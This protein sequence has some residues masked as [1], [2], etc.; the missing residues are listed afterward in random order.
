MFLPSWQAITDVYNDL[1][2][3]HADVF[4]RCY[5]FVLHSSLP[6]SEQQEVFHP[7]PPGD[8]VIFSWG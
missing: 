8:L 1:A 2:V 7:A 4:A 3:N 5:T 6:M